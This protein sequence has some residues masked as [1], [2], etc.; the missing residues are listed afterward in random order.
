M[1]LRVTAATAV[2]RGS[3]VIGDTYREHLVLFVGNIALATLSSLLGA[4]YL[5]K[6][7]RWKLS[8]P[9]SL[10]DSY[11]GAGNGTGR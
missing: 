11:N 5:E 8:W 4:I 9:E 10:K 1:K 7:L 6:Q 3:T 2:V